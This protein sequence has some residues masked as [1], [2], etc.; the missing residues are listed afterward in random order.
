MTLKYETDKRLQ[1]LIA[2][3]DEYTEWFMQ[4]VRRISYPLKGKNGKQFSMLDSFILWADEAR[5]GNMEPGL[6]QRLGNLHEDLRR[7]A[8]KLINDATKTG[9]PPDYD[10]YEQL[11]TFFEEF[12]Q[13]IR[14]LE[15]DSLLEDSGM[16]A[17]TGLRSSVALE[18][19][20]GRELDRLARQG[21]TFSIALIRIDNYQRIKEASSESI[22]QEYVK[23]LAELIKKSV[24]S[25]DDAYRLDT[26]E[27]VLSLKQSDMS[28]GVR[29]LE[30]LKKELENSH[31]MYVIDNRTV[32]LSLSSCIAM[33]EPGDNVRGLLANL[34]RD[35]D[36]SA[37]TEGTVLE[38]FE[39]SPLQRFV[40][41]GHGPED[42]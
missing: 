21:K 16:D 2:V 1:G 15:K 9:V 10:Q 31:A 23:L 33:P 22:V 30:R 36:V 11:I 35:L 42:N 25:Y 8:D 26:D 14:R 3:V 19:D 41:E 7:Q 40:K 20:F 17:L 13:H 37:K 12:I 18:K 4:V 24:R 6:L 28:G 27:F 29:A 32:P 38:Y 34:K 39:M 5:R